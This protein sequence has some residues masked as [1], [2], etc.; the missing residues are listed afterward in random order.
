MAQILHNFKTYTVVIEP[1]AQ[2]PPGT[3][4]EQTS[5]AGDNVL[6]TL[7]FNARTVFVEQQSRS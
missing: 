4:V 6:L 3:E 5:T 7:L 2:N 1:D